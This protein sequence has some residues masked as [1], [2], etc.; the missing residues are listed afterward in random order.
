MH[1]PGGYQ[2]KAPADARSDVFQMGVLIYELLSG[3][4]FNVVTGTFVEDITDGFFSENDDE[5]RPDVSDAFKGHRFTMP[6][7]KSCVTVSKCRCSRK[8]AQ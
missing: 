7:S 5:V 4:R 8:R 3:N 1:G 2:W 6:V